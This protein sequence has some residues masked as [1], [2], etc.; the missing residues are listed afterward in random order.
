[1]H[2]LPTPVESDVI[3]A[4]FT[5]ELS[6]FTLTLKISCKF[7]PFSCSRFCVLCVALLLSGNSS[8]EKVLAHKR[9][10]K[11]K[12]NFQPWN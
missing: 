5:D 1:M 4:L 10:N 3:P 12:R 11:Y 7:Q 6:R 2:M 8:A 9:K